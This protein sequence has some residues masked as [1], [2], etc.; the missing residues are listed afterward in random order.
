M[1][2]LTFALVFFG[3]SSAIVLTPAL[4]EMAEF[5]EEKGGG[6]YAQSYAL[7]NISYSFGMLFGPILGGFLYSEYGFC[8]QQWVFAMILICTA[9]ILLFFWHL[10][11]KKHL[12]SLLST[13]SEI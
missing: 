9:P 12:P 8:I 5:V 13:H 7:Y 6:L 3:F 10:K 1:V 2:G 4:P 11:V